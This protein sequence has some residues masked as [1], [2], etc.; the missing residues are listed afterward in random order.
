MT[1][2]SEISRLLLLAS[3][4]LAGL[5]I[6][7]CSDSE[8]SPTAPDAASDGGPTDGSDISDSD[9]SADDAQDPEPALTPEQAQALILS[10]PL[11][12]TR[13]VDGLQGDVHVLLTE[14]NVPHIYAANRRDLHRVQGY[15]QARDRYFQFEL[16][17][18]LGQGIVSELLGSLGLSIDQQ[19]VGQGQRALAIR[20][21][22]TA[23]T[24]QRQ[25]FDDFAA[26]INDYIVAAQ[27]GEVPAPSELATVAP[28]LGAENPTDL[29]QPVTGRDVAGFAA[30][31]VYQ[32]GFE[33]SDLQREAVRQAALDLTWPE[34]T[35]STD[36][37][38]AGVRQD[39]VEWIAPV[40]DVAS[41]SFPGAEKGLSRAFAQPAAARARSWAPVRAL[42]SSLRDRMSSTHARTEE[43]LLRGPLGDHGSNTWAV[44]T[45]LDGVNAL[46]AGDGHLSLG[47]APFF[48]QMGRHTWPFGQTDID[49]MGLYFPGL[50]MMGVGTNGRVA[51]SQTYLYGD[52]T[53]F[54]ALPVQLGADGLPQSWGDEAETLVRT[55]ETYVIAPVLG[56]GGTEVW[57]RWTT[58]AGLWMT[59]V[60]G[61]LL[62]DASDAE[63]GESVVNVLGNLVVPS[64]EDGDGVITGIF[65]DYVGF[66][67]GDTLGAVERFAQADN[68]EQFL[69]QTQ[70]L[71]AY[72]GNFVVA[73]RDGSIAYTSF[74]ATPCRLA[75]GGVNQ[76]NG[77]PWPAD[78]DPRFVITGDASGFEI[79][80]TSDR[81]VDESF[82][83]DPTRCV[84]GRDQ[85]PTRVDPEEGYVLNA[86][87]DPAGGTF[88]NDPYN[89]P[90]YLG[91]GYSTGYR[92][93]T[94]N[95]ELD[96]LTSGPVLAGA[97]AALAAMS[98]L[99]GNVDSATGR[100][101]VPPLLAAIEAARAEPGGGAGPIYSANQARF[102]EVVGR[103]QR[104]TER[105]MPAESGVVTFYEAPTADEVEDAV[106]TMIYNQWLKSVVAAT[107]NDELLD[108]FFALSPN[109]IRLRTLLLMLQH[110]GA[111]GGD[112]LASW[113]ET[114]GESVFFDDITTPGVET[115]DEIILTALATALDGLTA[116]S[117]RGDTGGFGTGDMSSWLWGMRHQVRFRSVLIEFAGGN[118]AVDLIAG[119][120]N[121][122]TDVLPLAPDIAA[123]D[124][125][126]RLQWFPRHGDLFAVDAP[127][128]PLTATDYFYSSGP[129]MRMV[130]ALGPNGVSGR[131]ILPGG[132]SGLIESPN[133]AD[134]AAL[135]LGNDT[136]PMRFSVEQVV[137]GATARET[138]QAP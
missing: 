138:F 46:L 38:T 100:D 86:N 77:E 5:F 2:T 137:A 44:N 1:A 131:N 10:V 127:N 103:L 8:S 107:F 108:E 87:N 84:V 59:D 115:S 24:E 101:F 85:W 14:A 72:A 39:I 132:Q 109:E 26:G 106:A 30:F 74:N 118:P 52:I 121:I 112:V 120:F 93:D 102:D 97:E 129:V 88:D 92:A 61:R 12:S 116:T 113:D 71:F 78:R 135:W 35:P 16:A 43:L 40:R 130:I 89:D 29:M 65:M 64:D 51:W 95:R 11:T 79:P 122:N 53:D 94:I 136:L 4:P 104:W 18:R 54:Y 55:D 119:D 41:A 37:R 82:A 21:Y 63:D 83:G 23:S 66:D 58:E 42:P 124:P 99:Q 7:S 50:P 125:R 25:A 32:L 6:A 13:T 80:S 15:I 31:I 27:A 114:T 75:L 3:L 17:R 67:L 56:S 128:Y 73:D 76:G 33:T 90:W 19:A 70:G 81:E 96:A 22:D 91:V 9:G 123:G 105:G 49:E 126:D 47:V 62:E 133:F 28:L 36:L 48:Y 69:E 20:I 60:E 134:Q 110:R 57:P 34:G 45:N 68:V 111:D 98:E 117:T